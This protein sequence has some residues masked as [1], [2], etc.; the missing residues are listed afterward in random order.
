VRGERG[1]LLALVDTGKFVEERHDVSLG[2]RV[3]TEKINSVRRR[4]G[5]CLEFGG[6][7]NPAKRSC[8]VTS[9]PP[10]IVAFSWSIA[11]ALSL[12]EP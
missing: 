9:V 12:T 7:S 2:S 3:G 6:R 8:T 10:N 4:P 11:R 1:E 5:Y